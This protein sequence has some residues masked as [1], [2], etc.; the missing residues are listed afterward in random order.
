MRFLLRRNDKKDGLNTNNA[1]FIFGE[2]IKKLK[3]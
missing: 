2:E 3:K 1:Y